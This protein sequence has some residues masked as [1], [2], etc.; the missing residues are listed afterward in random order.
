MFAFLSLYLPT[1]LLVLAKTTSHCCNFVVDIRIISQSWLSISYWVYIPVSSPLITIW[2]PIM[3][4][5]S[6][7][8]SHRIAIIVPIRVPTSRTTGSTMSTESDSWSLILIISVIIQ[9]F[10]GS[11]G[12][13]QYSDLVE[14]IPGITASAMS[15]VFVPFKER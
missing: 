11:R 4:P 2:P 13:E 12:T 9:I 6:S 8:T 7:S 5:T 10:V 14:K 1:D 3:S 15:Q